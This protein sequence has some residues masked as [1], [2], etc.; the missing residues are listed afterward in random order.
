[1]CRLIL[2][3]LNANALS[4]FKLKKKKH[5]SNKGNSKKNLTFSYCAQCMDV[6]HC[7]HS[8]KKSQNR[9][10]SYVYLMYFEFIIYI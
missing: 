1:M 10:T 2:T 3:V 7:I 4:K 9:Q 6:L 5:F 8:S